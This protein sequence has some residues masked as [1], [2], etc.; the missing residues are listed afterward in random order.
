MWPYPPQSAGPVC[1]ELSPASSRPLSLLAEGVRLG[2]RNPPEGESVGPLLLAHGA[3][4][5]SSH[6]FPGGWSP[7]SSFS[8]CP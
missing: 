4:P 3:D 5:G 2:S 7:M 6:N 8:P 1:S